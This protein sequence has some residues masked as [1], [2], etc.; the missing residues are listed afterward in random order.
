MDRRVSGRDR[1]EHV[2]NRSPTTGARLPGA[3]GP[4]VYAIGDV[5]GHLAILDQLLDLIGK[6][7]RAN[8]PSS[9]PQLVFL[10]DYVDRGPDSRGVLDRLLQLRTRPE[11]DVVALRGN[12][13]DALLRFL[14]DPG[15]AASW[16][17]NWGEAT[18]RA[19]GVDPWGGADVRS[20]F[21]N[22]FP[23]AHR[24]FL[25]SLPLTHEVGDYLFVHAGVRPGCPLDRQEA[26]DLM[27][28]RYD[29]LES[30]A[31]H[32]RVV[33]HGHTPAPSAQI[34]SN[35]IGLDTGVYYSGV[36]TAVRLEGETQQ[37]LQAV[38]R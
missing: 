9:R 31:D 7:L 1:G 19:Y 8:P 10:G 22:A 21:L 35:R 3:L 13:E 18:L 28:I 34:R 17:E 5:H 26:R 29:F 11:F 14:D 6:D 16:I 4:R 24:A 27:W 23:P 2:T 20:R 38:A 37:I 33:V 15:Y 36:L 25:E 32:G 30:D 12:H